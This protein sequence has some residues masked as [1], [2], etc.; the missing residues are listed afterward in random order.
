MIGFRLIRNFDTPYI[1]RSITEFW[2]RWHI[3]LSTWLRDYLYIPLGGNRLGKRR[4]TLN[5][6]VTMALGGLWHGANWTFVIWGALHGIGLAVER[7]VGF[8]SSENSSIWGRA[9]RALLLFQFVCFTW[10]FFRADSISASLRFLAAFMHRSEIHQVLP[11]V[12]FLA[13]FAALA[14]LIDIVSEWFMVE[15]AVALLHPAF[16]IAFALAGL[17]LVTAMSAG[18][19][20]PFIYFQF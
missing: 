2:R 17:L 18:V 14:A 3:S 19:P 12:G 16:Q 20:S 4:E 5:I 15:F 9:I 7:F 6:L 13:F 11:V 1:S 8:G 10:V